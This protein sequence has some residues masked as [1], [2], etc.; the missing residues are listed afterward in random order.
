MNFPE[1]EEKVLDFWKENDVFQKS[2]DIREG[3]PK[4]VFFEGPPTANGMPHPGHVLT[5][6]IKD[7]VLRYQT[8][9]GKQIARKAGWDT[10][11]LPVEL[12][13]E[14]SLGI[15]G[16]PQIEEYGVEAFVKKCKES[17][18]KYEQ[19]W[20]KMT[21]RLGFWVDLD[22]PY[23][24]YHDNYIESV[25]W[26]VKTIYDKGL[27]YKGYKVVPYCPR[28]GTAL[29][30]HEVAQGYKDIKEPSIFVQFK[31][32]D[33]ENEY[34]LV[35]T[36]TPWTLP[37]N[38]ALAVSEDADYAYVKAGGKTLILARDLVEAVMGEEMEYSID[39]VVKGRELL[40]IKYEPLFRFEEPEKEAW[41][42]IAGDY[43]TLTDGTGIVHIAPAFGEDDMRVSRQND[44][45][46]IQLVNTEGKFVESVTPWAGMFVKDADPKITAELKS[47]GMLFKVV[48]NEHS[49]PFCWRCD[50]PLLYYARSSWFIKMSE[51]RDKLLANNNTINWQPEHI[52]DGRFGNFLEN[53]IDWAVSRERYWGTPL[54]LWVCEDCGHVHAIGSKEELR[55]LATDM[56]DQIELH[57]PYIDNVHIK[58]PECGGMMVEKGN[59]CLCINE[60][61]GYVCAISENK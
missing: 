55:S 3:A 41:R 33:R 5:R 61:C 40:G 49:Y 32:M 43:V 53:V 54:P 31:V 22:D 8:M 9:C 51:V 30:S 50:T 46:V 56:P 59:K 48:Q 44:L 19:E 2:I 25:W 4:F 26:A 58:C 6:A 37:S 13:V 12:E 11:G 27:M 57:R 35:W 39:K 14:K 29:S 21:E 52:R 38:V 45:P 15:S 28:C 23:V 18:F 24:T 36:T 10:H 42:V 7:V 1:M 20:R 34:F 17:V 60:N 16:K 47:R